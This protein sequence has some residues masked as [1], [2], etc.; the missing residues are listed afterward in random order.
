MPKAVGTEASSTVG[1]AETLRKSFIAIRLIA[2]RRKHRQKDCVARRLSLCS[3]KEIARHEKRENMVV[4]ASMEPLLPESTRELED[5]A[6]ELTSAANRFAAIGLI[7]GEHD[8][9][10]RQL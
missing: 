7:S 10:A 8:P 6:I 5:V 3:K 2:D 4:L 9:I 1:T